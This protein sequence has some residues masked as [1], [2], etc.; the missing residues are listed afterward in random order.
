[1]NVIRQPYPIM[2]K[3]QLIF[4][5]LIFIFSCCNTT[6]KKSEKINTTS[7]TLSAVR[8]IKNFR[9]RASDTIYYY[10]PLDSEIQLF[11]T[12]INNVS[13]QM[14]T[15]CLNDSAVFNET[16]TEER[17]KNKKLIEF[18]VAHNFA[19]DFVIKTTDHEFNIRV[20]KECFKDSLGVDFIK[21][22]FMWKNEFSHCEQKNLIFKATLAKPD[23]DYQMAVLYM[24]SDGGKLQIIRVEDESN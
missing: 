13:Y 5:L 3:T 10:Y 17:S 6:T 21:I 14:K 16:W 11:D 4:S 22:C 24:I 9:G 18:A 19:T 2:K 8:N 1:M 12:V 15:F 20:T 23:T 7:D